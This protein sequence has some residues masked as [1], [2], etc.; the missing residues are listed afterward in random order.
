[1]SYKTKQKI[2]ENNKN[3]HYYW[4]GKHTKGSEAMQQKNKG[5][6]WYNNGN[7]DKRFKS[8]IEAFVFGYFNKGR[9]CSPN[10]NRKFSEAVRKNMS[11]AAKKRYNKHE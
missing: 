10:K 2:S 4:K 7:K 6:A 9:L 8:E 3:K 11:N 1:M 5:T